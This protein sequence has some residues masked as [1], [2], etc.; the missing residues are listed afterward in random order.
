M[1]SHLGTTSGPLSVRFF[2]LHSGY[3]HLRGSTQASGTI[4][5]IMLQV[6]LP[7]GGVD[8]KDD[9]TDGVQIPMLAL[10]QHPVCAT[11][12]ELPLPSL[13]QVCTQQRAELDHGV[14]PLVTVLLFACSQPRAVRCLT[15]ASLPLDTQCLVAVCGVFG[16][17]AG[18]AAELVDGTLKL[19]Y[20]TT[21]F[22]KRFTPG[23]LQGTVGG[24]VNGTALLLLSSWMMVVSQQRGSG[25]PGRHVPG[26]LFISGRT[27]GFQR[28]SD[29]KGC[30]S[31][32]PQ[33]REKRWACLA[34]FFI[35]MGLVDHAAGY[36]WNLLP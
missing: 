16:H 29:R 2:W 18:A 36:A 1:D 15:M 34:T 20:C 5:H 11:E 12:A 26:P 22:T 7:S 24:L 17:R 4:S 13:R 14:L 35:A 33:E 8:F 19:R 23:Q 32:T 9:A 6:C 10:R 25:Q 28:Q 21:S 3:I 31:Q 30:I 27:Q